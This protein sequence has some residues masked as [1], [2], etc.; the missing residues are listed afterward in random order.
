M[1]GFFS[2]ELKQVNWPRFSFLINR[3]VSLEPNF[4]LESFITAVANL[5]K[6]SSHFSQCFP[7][8]SCSAAAVKFQF[9]HCL[10]SG[11]VR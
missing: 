4:C 5:Y 1:S 10:K 9:D 3:H 8:E 2:L 7:N 11:S 6:D